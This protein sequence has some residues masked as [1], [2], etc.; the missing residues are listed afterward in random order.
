MSY[1]VGSNY[2]LQFTVQGEA[3]LG[4][5]LRRRDRMGRDVTTLRGRGKVNEGEQSGRGRE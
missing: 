2:T 4:H 5:S 1:V 3:S